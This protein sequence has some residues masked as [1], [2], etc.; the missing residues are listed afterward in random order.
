MARIR[1]FIEDNLDDPD[2]GPETIAA[3]CHISV[4]YLHKL[5]RTESTSVSRTIRD[6][7][8]EQCRRDLIAP[9]TR[10][11]TIST[12]G[13]HWGFLDAAHFSRVFKETYGL[14]PREYRL[15]R[16]LTG[17]VEMAAT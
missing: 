17:Q 4:G 16:D 6:R 11:T 5:F 14:S 8:L 3:A 9:T 13:A 7:R 12:I 1:C 10:T 15:S 2:L